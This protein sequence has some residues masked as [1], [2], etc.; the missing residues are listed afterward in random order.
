MLCMVVVGTVF[1]NERALAASTT[2]L[3]SQLTEMQSL[4]TQMLNY[5]TIGHLPQGGPV[6]SGTT[7]TV[8]TLKE[9]ITAMGTVNGGETIR[10]RPGVYDFFKPTPYSITTHDPAISGVK[11][12]NTSM[13][14]ITSDDPTNRAVLRGVEITVPYWRFENLSFRVPKGGNAFTT[15]NNVHDLKIIGNDVASENA[16]DAKTWDQTTWLAKTAGSFIGNSGPINSEIAYNNIRYMHF[17]ILAGAG[18]WVHDNKI[19]QI[20]GDASRAWGPGT[21]VENNYFADNYLVDANHNDFLQSY[22]ISPAKFVGGVTVRNNSFIGLDT[23][24]SQMAISPLAN[25]QGLGLFDGPY[26][27]WVVE[28]NLVVV[29]HEWHGIS[30]YGG[31]NST[32]RHNVV[33]DAIYSDSYGPSWLMLTDTKAGS[34]SINTTVT[35]NYST[36]LSIKGATATSGNM[37]ILGTDYPKYFKDAAH[38]DWTIVPG[39]LP[40]TVGATIDMSKLAPEPYKDL[41][42]PMDNSTVIPTNNTVG[43]VVGSTNVPTPPPTPA[44]TLTLSVSTTALTTGGTATLTWS[45]TNATA[46]TASDT[47]VGTKAVSGSESTG[48]QTSAGTKTFTL[49]CIGAGGSVTKSVSVTVTAPVVDPGTASGGSNSNSGGSTSSGSSGSTSGGSSGSSGGGSS[50]SDGSTGSTGS[51]DST[52]GG[53]SSGG[54]SNGSTG[55]TGSSSGSSESTDSTTNSGTGATTTSGTPSLRVVTT[56]MVNIRSTPLGAKIGT[57]GRGAQGTKSEAVPVAMGGNT[58]VYV[59]FDTGVDGYVAERY[60]AP[61]TTAQVTITQLLALLAQL[62]AQLKALRG[63]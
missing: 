23:E 46:C 41:V 27:D 38:F 3:Q 30:M 18:T 14:T 52:S 10:L 33:A 44:P 54:S 39:S 21:I 31:V 50:S 9:L 4:L 59:N 25:S 32:I 43:G 36:S 19:Q 57:H 24:A 42:T 5:L 17:G 26:Q 56:N 63:Y 13:V 40:F 55:S 37:K 51:T 58:W 7:I 47:W 16:F 48:S 6:V 12:H 8:S 28:N 22:V 61:A 35:D 49:A 11:P 29:T 20:S 1:P 15:Y 2:D 53:S 62:Q 34:S 45:S 60:L